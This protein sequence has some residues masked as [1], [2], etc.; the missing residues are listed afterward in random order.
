MSLSSQAGVRGKRLA[1]CVEALVGC[2]VA[3]GLAEG[4]ATRM[5]P[6]A[7]RPAP[8][9]AAAAAGSVEGAAPTGG[10][11]GGCRP[12]PPAAA[13]DSEP[14]PASLPLQHMQQELKE[15]LT[16]GADTT[17]GHTASREGAHAEGPWSLAVFVTDPAAGGTSSSGGGGGGTAA[18]ASLAASL[19]FCMGLGVLPH[20]AGEVLQQLLSTDPWDGSLGT[21]SSDRRGRAVGGQAAT[22]SGGAGGGGRDGKGVAACSA[23]VQR[24]TGYVFR[25][26]QLCAA[27][28]THVS[29]P[30]RA[31]P[32]V[33]TAAAAGGALGS[34]GGAGS[35]YQLLEFV[36][37][38]VVGLVASVWAYRWVP[39][40][41]HRCCS[42]QCSCLEC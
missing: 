8:S 6:A 27:A 9:A 7:V 35:H 5:T 10:T 37:D 1:D 31:P 25:N 12:R 3:A 41:S 34:A 28:V 20:D 38:A 26:P 4:A 32:T 15:W 23:A 18:A 30:Y 33:G 11:D 42:L 17:T 36:G 24:A 16:A 21:A 19:R 40:G 13:A 2:H 14:L 29:W 39:C 22:V